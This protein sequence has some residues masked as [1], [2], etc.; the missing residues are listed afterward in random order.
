[1][2]IHVRFS[3]V[4]DQWATPRELYKAL[5]DEFHFDFEACTTGGTDNDLATPATP[6]TGKRVFV[7]C[8]SSGPDIAEWVERGLQADIA[9]FLIPALSNTRWF[10]ANV[11]PKA[12]E[13]RFIRGRQNFG[14]A[15]NGAPCP[16]MMVIFEKRELSI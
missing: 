12:K 4:F 3:S 7:N 15:V 16:S 13:I 14:D 11:C 9:V 8:H 1:M 5:D 10:Y 2:N 6:W